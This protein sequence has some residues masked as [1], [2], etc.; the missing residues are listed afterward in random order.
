MEPKFYRVIVELETL[1]RRFN[2]VRDLG[3]NMSYLRVSD[4]VVDPVD[5][6]SFYI[7]HLYFQLRSRVAA[8]MAG[9][10]FRSEPMSKG[11]VI[12]NIILGRIVQDFT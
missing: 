10:L 1:N 6:T 11:Q 8:T 3:E 5:R 7:C 12:Y 2:I 4:N 9:S